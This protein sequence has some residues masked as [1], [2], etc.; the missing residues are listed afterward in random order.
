MG[1][2]HLLGLTEA[3]ELLGFATVTGGDIALTPLGETFAEASILA[4][5]EI[6]ATRIRRLPLFRWLLAMLRATHEKRLERDVAHAAL[7]LDFPAEVAARQLETIVNWGRYTELLAY[8]DTRDV[9][10]LE[11]AGAAAGHGG[12]PVKAE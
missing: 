9:F 7:E 11:P 4:R 8:D 6:C 3:A 2:D 5:K 12:T 1:S 10:Y